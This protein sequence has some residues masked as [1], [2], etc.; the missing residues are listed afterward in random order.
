MTSLLQHLFTADDHFSFL[1]V[2][3][4]HNLNRPRR[5]Y[6]AIL[7]VSRLLVRGAA[8]T[9]IVE[10]EFVTKYKNK[11]RIKVVWLVTNK[12]I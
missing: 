4:A 12:I 3:S 7:E 6:A 10:R 2:Y 5:A 11:E 8:K 1:R 9:K